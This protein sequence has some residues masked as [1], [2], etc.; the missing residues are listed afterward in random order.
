MQFPFQP[1]EEL[2][3]RLESVWLTTDLL[4]ST[5]RALAWQRAYESLPEDDLSAT[6][7]LMITDDGIEC[8]VATSVDGR[9][10]R[11]ATIVIDDA[12]T[13]AQLNEAIDDAMISTRCP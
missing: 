9:G 11:V 7:L 3:D 13:T 6:L 1:A 10:A 5:P 2:A 4:P 8:G 12:T